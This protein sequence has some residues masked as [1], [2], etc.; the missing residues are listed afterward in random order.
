[1]EEASLL[2]LPVVIL[3][4]LTEV[5]EAIT[6]SG[7]VFVK[8]IVPAVRSTFLYISYSI[9]TDGEAVGIIVVKAIIATFI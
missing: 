5:T 2:S 7:S 6:G 4:D 9:G 3:V 8:A 1:M